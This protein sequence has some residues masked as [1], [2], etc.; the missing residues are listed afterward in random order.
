MLVQHTVPSCRL[1]RSVTSTACF[2]NQCRVLYI[3]YTHQ[4]WVDL[5]VNGKGIGGFGKN[6]NPFVILIWIKEH[7][8]VIILVRLVGYGV[9]PVGFEFRNARILR[10]EMVAG[11][12]ILSVYIIPIKKGGLTKRNVDPWIWLGLGNWASLTRRGNWAQNPAHS[13]NFIK[14]TGPNF[15]RPPVT[16]SLSLSL[17]LSP[18]ARDTPPTYLCMVF[19]K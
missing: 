9:L 14:W 1:Y 19:S 13:F 6:Q 4:H 18:W 15:R 11:A 2:T 12:T 17:S 3:Y 5:E 16:P 10:L 8:N 7:W